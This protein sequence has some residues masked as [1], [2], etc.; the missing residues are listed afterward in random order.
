MIIDVT[1][2]DVPLRFQVT[3]SV[4]EPVRSPAPATSYTPPDYG[5]DMP[6]LGKQYRKKLDLTPQQVEW[7]DK[8]W[9]PH[10][11]FIELKGGC[12]ATIQLYLQALPALETAM[13]RKGASLAAVV[14]QTQ[15]ESLRLR[16]T[17]PNP[18]GYSWNEYD[19]GYQR[20]QIEATIYSTIFR[21]C[22]NVVRE[23]YGH[24]RKLAA[25]F[26]GMDGAL[27]AGL[28]ME[29][30]QFLDALLPSLAATISA[31]DEATELALNLQNVTRWKQQLEQLAAHLS[32][33]TAEAFAEGVQQLGQR[34][35]RNPALE[36]IFFEASKLMA[37]FDREAALRFYLQYVYHDLNSVTINNKP[38]AKTIQKS[39][40]PQPD[41]LQR[42][43]AIINQLV[44]D[45][46]LP[47]AL[48]QVPTVYARQRRKIELDLGAIR[49]VQHQHAGTVELLNE[50]LQDEPE[51]T[52][53]PVSIPP[54]APF[55][56]E[57][58]PEEEIQL[59]V[60]AP[61]PVVT[62]TSGAFAAAW[63]LTATQEALLARFA[64]QELTLPQAEVEAFA[65]QHGALRNQ[66]IDSINEQCYERLDDVLI[67]EDGDT[68]TIY[69]SYYQQLATP[70]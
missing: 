16:K 6:K 65:R 52:A 25:E 56:S 27:A 60:L 20:D 22:E 33:T 19:E 13:Q 35:A 8:F 39:L 55:V 48:S 47:Q 46:N 63:A 59:A 66:L 57:A 44:Q 9:P 31:P 50:Y 64:A 53:A 37:R 41:Q 42:F 54:L 17:T 51:T 18:Y 32:T 15:E 38:L 34:N 36:N 58:L 67:E 10:N 45:K 28:E 14:A 26:T 29:L 2:Q 68:Y 11:V 43:E 61:A 12:V 70:C 21:R 62:T 24:K 7:L 40:F 5:Y 49:A 30:G 69:E 23:A 1:G 4:T 3:V